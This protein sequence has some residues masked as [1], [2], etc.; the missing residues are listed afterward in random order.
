MGP[1]RGLDSDPLGMVHCKSR[2]I[3]FSLYKQGPTVELVLMVENELV[4]AKLNR[5]VYV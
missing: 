2:A 5:L 4:S 1:F 3:S